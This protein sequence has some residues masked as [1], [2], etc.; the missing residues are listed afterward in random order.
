MRSLNL[1]Y[2]LAIFGFFGVAGLHRF[3]LGK[4][5][6]G[7]IWL[8]TGGLFWIGTVYD[9]VTMEEQV[10]EAN[11]RALGPGH[12]PQALG[13]GY[14]PYPPQRPA[15]PHPRD[16]SVDLELRVLSLAR[17]H[18]GKLTAAIAA[19]ELGVPIAEA[20]AKLTDLAKGDHANIEVTDE[21]VVYY[22]F[23]ALRMT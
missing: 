5:V 14:H 16:A 11:R 13:P 22:D 3:Y 20:D 17:Q 8:L 10:R 23:P 21:G 9:L 12:R 15:A 19:A 4:P 18:G 6:T 7:I 1:S 2:L